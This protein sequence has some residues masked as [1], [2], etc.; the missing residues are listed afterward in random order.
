MSFRIEKYI[1][2]FDHYWDGLK[3]IMEMSKE[4]INKPENN[5]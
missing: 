3:N 5:G 1:I 4:R 2:L